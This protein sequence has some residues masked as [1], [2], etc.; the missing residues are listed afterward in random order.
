MGF[1]KSHAC[2]IKLT[3]AEVC[4]RARKGL[5]VLVFLCL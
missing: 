2:K 1:K 5:F 3:F 4:V